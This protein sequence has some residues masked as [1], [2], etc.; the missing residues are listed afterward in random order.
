VAA[1]FGHGSEDD[2]AIGVHGENRETGAVNIIY[3]SKK[4][5]SAPQNEIWSQASPGIDGDAEQDDA[6]G[7]TLAAGHF[8]PGGYADLAVGVLNDGV[9][10]A[11]GAGAV[12]IINGSTDGLTARGSRRWS[13]NSPAVLGRSESGDLFGYSLA[14]GRFTGGPTDDLAIGVPCENSNRGAVAVI[15]GSTRGLSSEGNQL[16]SQA[17]PGIAGEPK[18]DETF[19]WSLAAG[20]FGQDQTGEIFADLAIRTPGEPVLAA[21]RH[22]PGRSVTRA[23]ASTSACANSSRPWAPLRKTSTTW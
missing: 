18:P 9:G 5:L 14:A 3:G 6:F 16:W 7:W 1:N 2:L 8:R 4:G 22:S 23:S 20:S 10:R 12:N 21:A 15:H 13:Q 19:G 17:S 11:W